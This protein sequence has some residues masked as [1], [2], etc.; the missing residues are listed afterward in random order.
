M[1]PRKKNSMV[2]I[3]C[4]ILSTAVLT[5]FIVLPKPLAEAAD[6]P[7]SKPESTDCVSYDS[8]IEEPIQMI[9]VSS[10][11]PLDY[12]LQEKLQEFCG[13]F[14][15]PYEIVLAVIY[16]ESRFDSTA[17]NGSCV[18][19]MQINMVNLEW[20]NREIGITDLHDPVQNL[21]AGTYM[22]GELFEK[23]GEANMALTAYNHG[24]AGARKKY[25]SRGKISCPYSESVIDNSF[26][27][28]K[29]LEENK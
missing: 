7:E 4:A 14:G 23:Y 25:F 17:R 22:L 20:L 19:Y 10:S 11:I 16:Q 15:V 13:D 8:C 3:G 9:F 28:K 6:A 29:I 24:E 2:A 21:M 5:S 18:G 26:E 12:Q 1:R 27:W